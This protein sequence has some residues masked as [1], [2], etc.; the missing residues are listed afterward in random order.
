[1]VP[2]G[3]GRGPVWLEYSVAVL[4]ITSL[5]PLF[6]AWSGGFAFWAWHKGR[7]PLLWAVLG[8]FMPGLA[9]FFL[10]FCENKRRQATETSSLVEPSEPLPA[11]PEPDLL[12]LMPAGDVET[13]DSGLL[14]ESGDAPALSGDSGVGPS[15]SRRLSLWPHAAIVVAMLVLVVASSMV[16]FLVLRVNDLSTQVATLATTTTVEPTT[17]SIQRT[18]TTLLWRSDLDLSLYRVKFVR[19]DAAREKLLKTV[20]GVPGNYAKNHAKA[21]IGDIDWLAM[22]VSGMS[23]SPPKVRAAQDAYWEALS[24]LKESAVR[25][26]GNDSQTNVDRFNDAWNEEDKCRVKWAREYGRSLEP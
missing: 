26:I 17:T 9:F 19:I 7:A 5:P 15:S 23:W 18:T 14:A 3:S 11:P 10:A 21:I 20:E 24:E 16:V 25:V 6:L 12:E 22:L 4:S 8:V 2:G 1:M 13:P